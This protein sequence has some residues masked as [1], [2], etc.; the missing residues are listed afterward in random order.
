MDCFFCK[1]PIGLATDRIGDRENVVY[2]NNPMPKVGDEVWIYESVHFNKI[3][4]SIVEGEDKKRQ[5][6]VVRSAYMLDQNYFDEYGRPKKFTVEKYISADNP[7]DPHG[8]ILL[9]H[10]EKRGLVEHTTIN[11][12]ELIVGCCY[13][14]LANEQL[15]LDLKQKLITDWVPSRRALPDS[16][17]KGFNF[18]E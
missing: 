2:M 15:R 13:L 12:R 14:A 6:V 17:D 11:T 5:E 18:D 16:G 7:L 9:S 4:H 1:K 8:K 3:L 10:A